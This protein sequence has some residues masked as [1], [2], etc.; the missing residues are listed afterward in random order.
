VAKRRGEAPDGMW[1]DFK[2][3]CPGLD[4]IGSGRAPGRFWTEFKD[5]LVG[6]A[7]EIGSGQ[8]S[9]RFVGDGV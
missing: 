7:L 8:A 1:S 2:E 4:I 9:G 3:I 5:S 6:T